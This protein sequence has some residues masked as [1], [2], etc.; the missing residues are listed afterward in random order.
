MK[1]LRERRR[2]R[3]RGLGVARREYNTLKLR[4]LSIV[5]VVDTLLRFS[6]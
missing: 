5:V 1:E 4:F 6:W 3:R 2:R